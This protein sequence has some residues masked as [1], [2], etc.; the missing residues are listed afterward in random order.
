M[1]IAFTTKG[2]DWNSV[3]DP[4]FGRT[5]YLLIYDE[6]KNETSSFDNRETAK[7]AH[8]VGPKTAKTI[9]DLGVKIL[10]TGNGPGGNAGTILEKTGITVFVGAENMTAKEAYEAYKYNKLTQ[11]TI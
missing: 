4:R 7:E 11:F 6:E 8:G 3:V 10:I 1:I 5:E 9:F 2:T